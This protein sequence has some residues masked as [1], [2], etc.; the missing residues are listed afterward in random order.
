MASWV[1]WK[2]TGAVGCQTRLIKLVDRLDL[3]YGREESKTTW[4]SS[5]SIC[6]AG[7]ASCWDVNGGQVW[8]SKPRIYLQSCEV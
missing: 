1:G 7:L 2:W 6:E 5:V 8:E 4:A 3:G